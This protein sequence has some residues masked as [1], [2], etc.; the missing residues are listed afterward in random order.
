MLTMERI[1]L[2]DEEADK[3]KQNPWR[4]KESIQEQIGLA[5]QKDNESEV[6]TDNAGLQERALNIGAFELPKKQ[7]KSYWNSRTD[8]WRKI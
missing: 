2:I 6:I 1:D 3:K 7:E 5:W 8:W 4:W